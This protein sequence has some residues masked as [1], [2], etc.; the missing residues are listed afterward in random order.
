MLVD[1]SSIF[2]LTWSYKETALYLFSAGQTKISN[3]T[4]STFR[5]AFQEERGF[6]L[7][8]N[9]FSRVLKQQQK[10]QITSELSAWRNTMQNEIAFLWEFGWPSSFSKIMMLLK[11]SWF[12]LQSLE[13]VRKGARCIGESE[14]DAVRCNLCSGSAW[15]YP[16]IQTFGHFSMCVESG[17]SGMCGEEPV[18]SKTNRALCCYCTLPLSCVYIS[19]HFTPWNCFSL[20]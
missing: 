8:T 18:K 3:S 6:V 11:A 2:F 20:F 19:N 1:V 7:C 9:T 4:V 15:S 5:K 13:C 10:S 16:C 14:G 17:S 12:I